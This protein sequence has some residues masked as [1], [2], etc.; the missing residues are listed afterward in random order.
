M[1]RA[2]MTAVFVAIICAG[3]GR[4]QAGEA[5]PTR[6]DPSTKVEPKAVDVKA[7]VKALLAEALKAEDLWTALQLDAYAQAKLAAKQAVQLG[8]TEIIGDPLLAFPA[9][10]H[11]VWDRGDAVGVVAGLRYYHLAPDGR[12]LALSTPLTFTPGSGGPNAAALSVD[13]KWLAY[14][15]RQRT[16]TVHMHLV[17]RAVPGGAER[18]RVSMPAVAG[19][20]LDNMVV[21]DDGSAVMASVFDG[22][23]A[24]PR[25]FVARSSAKGEAGAGMGEVVPAYFR[26][27]GIGP[28]GGWLLAEPWAARN[29]DERQYA[30]IHGAKVELGVTAASSGGLA[31]IVTAVPE[32]GF[33]VKVA[34]AEGITTVLP[35]PAIM[36]R[37]AK[38]RTVGGWL[39]V[40]TGYRGM[41]E[42]GV[43]LLG[44]PVKGER[45][46]FTTFAYRW[47]DLVE[48]QKAQPV[49]QSVSNFAIS[50]TEPATAY[51]WRE[52][53]VVE[54]DFSGSDPQE[55]KFATA[56][57]PIY[58]LDAVHQRLKIVYDDDSA[59]VLDSKG[60]TLWLGTGTGYWL[61]APEWMVLRTGSGAEV[62][63]H[64]IRLSAD[65]Q[66]R[67]A[68]KLQ[69][70]PGPWEISVDV[71]GRRVVASTDER[72]FE[73]D[74]I[75]GKARRKSAPGVRA[76]LV[77]MHDSSP[78]RFTRSYG[79]LVDKSAPAPTQGED[80]MRRLAP[81]DAWKVGPA[82]L[83]Y[84]Q[85]G[86]VFAPGR[87][88]GP[89][90]AIG[91]CETGDH[92]ALFKGALAIAGT[93]NLLAATF[94]PGPIIAK[95]LPVP[96]PPAEPLPGGSWRID[97]LTFAS[98][99]AGTLAWDA[100]RAGFYPRLLRSPPASPGLLVI[101][102]SVVIDLD[103][104][105]ARLFG[106]PVK[107]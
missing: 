8:N 76:P 50:D 82:L 64:V 57:G 96:P 93:G 6:T 83:I 41:T 17:V 69:L 59:Q 104:A 89:M 16:P 87:K 48:P 26:P 51:A 37:S 95:D 44:N 20:Y 9:R 4:A 107:E 56:S 81:R 61:Q 90:A 105:Y 78:G 68:A 55:R 27:H 30:L 79:R 60:Q 3:V 84:D 45:Q 15:E 101:T 74:A 80:P 106:S 11:S 32:A 42:D 49:W 7:K 52:L 29:A 47:K 34:N 33:L 38:L 63:W 53:Q 14:G 10:I 94:A 5:Q 12:P 24:R 2:A 39:L 73:L 28:D 99:K 100:V 35:V 77:E 102:A 72:W 1:R 65:P 54:V 103:P 40:G 67:S 86:Q 98:P 91:T 31:A 88:R 18:I 46:P 23:D 21:A 19:D 58:S 36:T 85:S 25:L 13:G 66:A 70:D 75:T 92:F 97:E 71:Y 43:D 62:A 22:D